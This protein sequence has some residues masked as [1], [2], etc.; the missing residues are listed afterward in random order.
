MTV[1]RQRPGE[2]TQRSTTRSERLAVTEALK[3]VGRVGAVLDVA[4]GNGRW[5]E[6]LTRK[7]RSSIIHF[8]MSAE[9]LAAARG[10]AKQ[11]RPIHGYV[12]GDAGALPFR[13]QIFDLVVCLEFLPYVRRS[14]GRI[15]A[16]AEMRRVSRRWVVVEYRHRQ[17]LHLAWQRLRLRLGLEARFPRNHF[18]YEQIDDELRRAGLG[19]RQVFPVGGLTSRS[20]VILAEAPSPDWMTGN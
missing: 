19:L 16:L 11:G 14:G 15:R 5:T 9:L 10:A 17:G 3:V 2:G 12:R 18:S 7:R 20:W 1:S 8:D 13:T 4:S 6:L